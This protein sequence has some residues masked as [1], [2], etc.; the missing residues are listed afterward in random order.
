M[1]VSHNYI[2]VLRERPL[3]MAGRGGGA[4]VLRPI[5]MGG[6]GGGGA[7]FFSIF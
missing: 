7:I 3:F 5:L 1:L 4:K 2:Y 6:G